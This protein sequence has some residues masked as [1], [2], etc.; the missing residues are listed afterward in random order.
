MRRILI[1]GGTGQVGTE[2][3]NRSWPSD[4]ELV[5]PTRQELDLSDCDAIEELITGGDF[6][7]V[8]NSGAYTA[9]DRAESDVAT[10]WK[11]NALAP[12]VIAAATKRQGIPLVHVSTDYVFDGTKDGPYLED[13]PVSPLCVYG[14]SKEAGEQAVRTGNPRHII[15]RT[16]WVFSPYGSN[17]VTTMLR[18]GEE[19]TLLR[20][21]DDQCGSPTSASDV[22]SAIAAIVRQLIEQDTAPIGT[23][24]FVNSGQATWYGFAQEIFQLRK[25]DGYNSPTLEAIRTDQYPTPARRPANSRLSTDKLR[26]DFGIEPRPWNAALRQTLLQLSKQHKID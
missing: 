16:A 7:A 1:T 13:D 4:I 17:F 14:G 19:R 3:R 15:L 23:Y 22:A 2:L 11:V 26:R 8:I 12:A 25:G 10:A 5:A 24:N 20:V 18:L 6:C 9:V 21:V